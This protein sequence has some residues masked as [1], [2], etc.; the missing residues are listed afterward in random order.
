VELFRIG[1]LGAKNL[2]D[3]E[4]APLG[5]ICLAGA[6]GEIWVIS[7]AQRDGSACLWQPLWTITR[8]AILA[9]SLTNAMWIDEDFTCFKHVM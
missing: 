3:F 7:D 4:G 6:W 9:L 2:R 5:E 8:L 1:G